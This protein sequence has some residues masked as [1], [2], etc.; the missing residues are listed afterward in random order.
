MQDEDRDV[1]TATTPESLARFQNHNYML[2]ALTV[3]LS[4]EPDSARTSEY[5]LKVLEVL[6]TR[7]D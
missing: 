4:L 5:K 1:W 3:R 2:Q 7:L 6:K